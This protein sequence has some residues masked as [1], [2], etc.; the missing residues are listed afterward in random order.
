MQQIWAKDL[1]NEMNVALVFS[2]TLIVMGNT[3][4]RLASN[5]AFRVWIN[6]EFFSYGPRRKAHG[7]A[8]INEYNLQ[9]YAGQS[10]KIDVEC[11]SYRVEN[12]YI[13]NQV[14]FFAAEIER[15]GAIIANSFDFKGYKNASRL[16]KVQRFAYQRGFVEAYKI[17]GKETL[18][19]IETDEQT[20]CALEESCVPYPKFTYL[21]AEEF[22]SGNIFEKSVF[23]EY[24]DSYLNR[25]NA[26]YYS[27]EEQEYRITLE[28]DRYGFEKTDAVGEELCRQYKAYRL[29]RNAA[30]FIALDIE[31]LDDANIML[32]YDEK[33]S[34]VQYVYCEKFRSNSTDET[35][36]SVDRSSTYRSG[37][38]NI[39]VYR[40][41]SISLINYKLTRGRY[42]LIAF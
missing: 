11:V 40:L 20:V 14:P 15:D 29:P 41:H 26:K 8:A 37:A 25:R 22:E 35:N 23:E 1:R 24:D 19:P 33:L 2:H 38:S 31:V 5:V 39:D 4:L 9:K 21:K 34:S 6:G 18:I 28:N 36:L 32:N 27:R 30:G 7:R 17:D 16:Q 13:V 42:A 3:V 12:F 10:V